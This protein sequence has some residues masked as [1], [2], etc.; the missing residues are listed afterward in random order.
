MF[1]IRK[2]ESLSAMTG[3]IH[4]LRGVDVLFSDDNKIAGTIGRAQ[5]VMISRKL[6]ILN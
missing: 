1:Y 5:A 2:A 6:Y 4:T 3:N